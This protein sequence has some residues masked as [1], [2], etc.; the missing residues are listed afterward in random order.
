MCPKMGLV[1]WSPPILTSSA[2]PHLQK[3]PFLVKI[4]YAL[5]INSFKD[6]A[7]IDKLFG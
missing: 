4:F 7:K 6:S 2:Q 1:L 5:E 3:Q